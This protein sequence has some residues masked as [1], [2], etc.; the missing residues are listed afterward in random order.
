MVFGHRRAPP[1][2]RPH[3]GHQLAQAEGLGHVVAGAELEAEDHVDLGIAR[4]HHD[5][6]HRLEGP[7]LLAELDPRLVGQHDVQQDDVGVDPVKE[8]QGLMAVTGDLDGKALPGQA[9]GQG[10][11]VGL[12]IVDHQHH[13]PVVAGRTVGRLSTTRHRYDGHGSRKS[14]RVGR[15]RSYGAVGAERGRRRRRT[16]GRIHRRRLGAQGGKDLRE[17]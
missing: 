8:A 6:G 14:G 9:R 17:P 10:L 3:T 11:A 16:G 5:D 2:H 15:V 7:H 1:Q 13:G 4:R 12:L